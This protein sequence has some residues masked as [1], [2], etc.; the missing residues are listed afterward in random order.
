[1]PGMTRGARVVAALAVTVALIAT[2]VLA[3]RASYGA[4]KGGYTIV[5]SFDKAAYGFGPNTEVDY[6]GVQVGHVTHVGLLADDR[7]DAMLKIDAGFQVPVGTTLD[8]ENRSLFGD[9]FVALQFPP[10]TPTRFLTNGD[11]ITATS[12]EAD[13]ADLI[14]HATPLLSQINGQDLLTLV[15]ELDEA[16]QGEGAKIAQSIHDGAQLTN[17]YADTI[18]AQLKALDA[19]SAFQTAI[20]P[21]AT[22]LDQLAATSNEALPTLNA[23][24]ADFQQ[25]L[26]TI[27]PFAAN[28]ANIIAQERPNIDALLARGDNVVRLLAMREPQVE[29]TVDGLAQ[30]LQKFALGA[31]PETL[32]DGTKF[33]YFKAFV[34]LSD[35][36]KLICGLVDPSQ[37]SSVPTQL[38]PLVAALSGTA[39]GCKASAASAAPA[40][41][42][43]NATP[44][45]SLPASAQSAASDLANQVANQVSAPEPTQDGTIGDLLNR[46]LGGP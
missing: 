14:N 18:N 15:T 37:G 24:E 26:Q 9:P 23:A 5:G 3:I 2:A 16:T 7:V 38:Q 45:G 30:Y 35:I 33:I 42:A 21:D 4:F 40:T 31:G 17:L 13:T 6:L 12:V 39:L 44:A 10:G 34:E 11:L 46:L 25:A 20:T 27:Q 28:L 36:Q 29:Q 1:M 43:P 32:P 41:P 19:F 22:T 8:V